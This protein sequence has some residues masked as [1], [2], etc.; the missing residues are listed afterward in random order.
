MVMSL[1]GVTRGVRGTPKL[2]TVVEQQ[3]LTQQT[4]LHGVKLHLVT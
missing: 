3:L 1:T 2:H 4:L